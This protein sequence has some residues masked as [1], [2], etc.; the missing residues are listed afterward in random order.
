MKE[1]VIQ[2]EIVILRELTCVI[3]PIMDDCIDSHVLKDGVY[4]Q[5]GFQF[6]LLA[7]LCFLQNLDQLF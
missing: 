7:G 4:V 5:D 6:P 1:A 3:V 2:V